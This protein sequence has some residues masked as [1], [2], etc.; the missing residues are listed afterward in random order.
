M[1]IDETLRSLII[2]ALK[3]VNLLGW[4]HSR[5]ADFPDDWWWH[6]EEGKT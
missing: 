2:P 5:G 4:C 3:R 1:Q 6:V